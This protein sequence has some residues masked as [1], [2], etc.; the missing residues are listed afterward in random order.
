MRSIS[1][2]MD[3]RRLFSVRAN[4]LVGCGVVLLIVFLPDVVSRHRGVRQV[5]LVFAGLAIAAGWYFFAK[6][7][8]PNN[9][10]RSLVGLV[11]SVCLTASLPVFLFEMSQTKWLMR[12]PLHK[13]FSMYVWPWG[14]YWE[15][16]GYIPVL[17]NVAGCF[18][19]RGWARRAFVASGI[20]LLILRQSMGTWVY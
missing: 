12:H 9:N 8:Q 14:H 18:F 5:L 17:L 4:F 20:L 13:V 3:R 11:A 1:P 7:K 6:D 2:D 15:L 19:G 16:N 10:W